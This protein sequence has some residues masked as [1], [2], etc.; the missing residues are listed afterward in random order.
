MNSA[1][2]DFADRFDPAELQDGFDRTL[3]SGLFSFITRQEFR[4]KSIEKNE[5]NRKRTKETRR[6]ATEAQAEEEEQ[7]NKNNCRTATRHCRLNAKICVIAG[8]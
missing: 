7:Q 6:R 4:E 1:F 2:I 5:R 3:G 8:H